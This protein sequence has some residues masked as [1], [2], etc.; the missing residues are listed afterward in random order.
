MKILHK[1]RKGVAQVF[2]RGTKN[3]ED[4]W[5]EMVKNMKQKSLQTREL[6]NLIEKGR[7]YCERDN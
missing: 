2:C 6:E 3:K 4:E 1:E 5:D 7:A